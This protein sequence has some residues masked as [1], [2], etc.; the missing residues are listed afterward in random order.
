MIIP[1][2]PA[3]ALGA[4]VDPLPKVGQQVHPGAQ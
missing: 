2:L 4:K 1:R 3:V